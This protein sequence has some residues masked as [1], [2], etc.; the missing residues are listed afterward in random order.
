LEDKALSDDEEL[1]TPQFVAADLSMKLNSLSH[2]RVMGKGPAYVK[3]GDGP[4]AL[5]RYPASKYY[6]FRRSFKLRN[7][8]SELV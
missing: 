1:L 6:E 5:V 3:I 2:W 7:S 4:K 8:T